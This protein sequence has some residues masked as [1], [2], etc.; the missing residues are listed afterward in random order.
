M[1]PISTDGV[2]DAVDGAAPCPNTA[3][4]WAYEI[5]ADRSHLGGECLVVRNE[6]A[7]LDPKYALLLMLLPP[8]LLLLLVLF[9]LLLIFVADRCTMVHLTSVICLGTKEVI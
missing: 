1:V 8:L 4:P 2:I 5:V 6:T 9:P 7:V 3:T